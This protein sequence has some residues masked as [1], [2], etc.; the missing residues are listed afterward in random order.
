M[1]DKI[2]DTELQALLE[3]AQA[4]KQRAAAP[5]AGSSMSYD[6]RR[7]QLLNKDQ[8]RIVE[9]VH[10]HFARLFSAT[11][12][13]SMR[14]VVDVEIAFIDQVLYAEF[15]QSLPTPCSAYSFTVAPSGG[16]SVLAFAP[17]LLMAVIDRALGGKGRSPADTPRPLTQIETPLINKLS[18]RLLHNLEEAWEPRAPIKVSDAAL[19]TSPEFIQA[20]APGDG[21]VLVALEAHTASA[22]GL[23]HL[24]YP[25][26]VLDP[27]LP[28]RA[29]APAGKRAG[30]AGRPADLE[31]HALGK[32]KVPV[33]IQLA[34]G[35][36]PLGEVAALRPGDVVR[37]DTQKQE[38][39][40]VFIG[41]HPKF[42]GRPGLRQNKRAVQIM[43]HIAPE[44]EDLYR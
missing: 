23:I 40:V 19:E 37:L 17:E 12:A 3:A 18:A 44:D 41:G 21:V 32:V 27:L 5:P 24:C 25:L 30:G 31:A 35:G 33:V 22:G 16:R 9:T 4:R 26:M 29:A 7:P 6:F 2:T 39:A 20:T 1:A 14:M 28:K 36:L 43:A 15:V 34:R 42:L 11:L 8:L 13:S 10:E 38:P